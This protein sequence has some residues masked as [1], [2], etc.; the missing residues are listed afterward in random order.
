VAV[1]LDAAAKKLA[2]SATRWLYARERADIPVA[3]A[4]RTFRRALR[5]I[6]IPRDLRGHRARAEDVV[7]TQQTDETAIVSWTVVDV[8][9]RYSIAITMV[10]QG[11]RWRAEEHGA[12]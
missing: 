5:E 8:R 12:D 6:F 9:S 2:A 7:A 3:P 11:G 1:P 4:T 10:L